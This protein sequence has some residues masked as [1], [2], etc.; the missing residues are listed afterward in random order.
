MKLGT[1]GRFTQ[2][3]PLYKGEKFTKCILVPIVKVCTRRK[4]L[5][6]KSFCFRREV[7]RKWQEKQGPH[8]TYGNLLKVFVNARHKECAEGL[9]ELLRK[10][11]ETVAKPDPS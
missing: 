2:E 3:S 10:K 1:L 4:P 11:C 5:L 9:C 6:I 8:A 7:L